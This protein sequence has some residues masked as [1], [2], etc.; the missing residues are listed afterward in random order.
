VSVPRAAQRAMHAELRAMLVAYL[1]PWL[2]A[3]A[4]ATPAR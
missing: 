2:D 4:P 1:R 3:P